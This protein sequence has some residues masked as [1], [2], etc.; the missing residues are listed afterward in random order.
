MLLLRVVRAAIAANV[1]ELDRAVVSDP[2]L[3]LRSV[4]VLSRLLG[5]AAAA[6]IPLTTRRRQRGQ[7][8]V[9]IDTPA[10]LFGN[11]AHF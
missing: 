6:L 4:D 2:S 3:P 8:R 5:S 10:T 11:A 1:I 9:D 7:A